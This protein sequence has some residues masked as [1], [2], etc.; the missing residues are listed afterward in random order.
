MIHPEPDSADDF[1]GVRVG[2]EDGE[3]GFRCA[4]VGVGQGGDA[5]NLD[6]S[7]GVIL[8]LQLQLAK[9]GAQLTELTPSQASYIGVTPEGP[10]KPDSYRY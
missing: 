7:G 8:G 10:Y 3:S 4:K 2:A 6:R 9:L 1:V 5:G